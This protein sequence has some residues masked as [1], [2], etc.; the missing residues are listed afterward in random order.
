MMSYEL[1]E[2]VNN[3]EKTVGFW[4]RRNLITRFLLYRGL[5]LLSFFLYGLLKFS[6]IT[7][8]FSNLIIFFGFYSLTDF[9]TLIFFR[10]TKKILLLFFSELILI[11]IL[12]IFP[13]SYSVHTPKVYFILVYSY[14]I[15]CLLVY[16]LILISSIF[17][18]QKVITTTEFASPVSK[19]NLDNY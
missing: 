5:T 16:I 7:N 1:E 4:I 9:I 3:I 10:T 2:N 13:W 11:Q 6:S 18:K 12:L 19:K 14:I 17:V 15:S 8:W